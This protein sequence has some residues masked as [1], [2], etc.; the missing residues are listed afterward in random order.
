[1]KK[2]ETDAQY[3]KALKQIDE[4]MLKI[5]D[6][7]SFDNPEFVMMDRLSDL[8]TDYEDQHYKIETPS[9][10]EVIKLRMYEM[11]LKQSDLAQLLGVSKSRISEYLRGKRD[12]TLDVA[13]KLHNQ[14]K[15]DGDIILQ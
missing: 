3:Q 9:L 13:R 14:L 6:D 12:I 1:M 11:G 8:V 5:G 15:I 2:I 7:H 10:I 4:L